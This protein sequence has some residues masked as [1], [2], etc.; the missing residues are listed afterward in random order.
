MQNLQKGLNYIMTGDVTGNFG[1]HIGDTVRIKKV[2]VLKTAAV[3]TAAFA[4][5]GPIGGA[6]GAM[7]A[8]HRMGGF[9]AYLDVGDPKFKPDQELLG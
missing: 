4:V 2:G 3:A 7:L 8:E 6:V 1:R 9:L 5:A